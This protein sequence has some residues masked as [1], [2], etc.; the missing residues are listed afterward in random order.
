MIVLSASYSATEA[1][2]APTAEFI[3]ST[4]G[5][6][7]TVYYAQTVARSDVLIAA[8]LILV[9]IGLALFYG[10]AAIQKRVV[11]WQ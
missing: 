6:G 4:S 8:A 10:V 9:V 3:G 11:Y 7:H 2:S 5:L 1:Q